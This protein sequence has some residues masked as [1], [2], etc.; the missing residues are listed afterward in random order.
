M[1]WRTLP[2]PPR[3]AGTP[4]PDAHKIDRSR[5]PVFYELNMQGERL[6]RVEVRP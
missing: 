1:N 6:H 2:P 5:P 3:Q 4:F